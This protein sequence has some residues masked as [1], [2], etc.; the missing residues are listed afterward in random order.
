MNDLYGHD[1]GDRILI[2][3]AELIREAVHEEDPA[4]RL[5][6]DEFIA[7][8]KNTMDEDD[9]A[10]VCRILNQGIVKS[11]KEYM[12]ADMNIP[13]GASI[14]AVRVPLDGNE[15]DEVF[16]LADKAL[17]NVKQNGKHGYAFYRRSGEEKTKEQQEAEQ[18]ALTKIMQVIGERNEGKGAYFVNF[19]RMQVLYRYLKRESLGGAQ[20][21]VCTD[22]PVA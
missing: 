8:L 12:G 7:F 21:N 13:L 19:D 22:Q 18:G 11:A 15:F 4:G 5:G 16:R 6:G 20:G 10:E 3:F 17:Y 9:V 14:G 2:R 1:M